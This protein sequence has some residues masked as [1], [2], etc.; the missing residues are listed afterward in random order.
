MVKI[1]VNDVS[2]EPEELA[3]LDVKKYEE[4]PTFFALYPTFYNCRIL[5]SPI[6]IQRML[7]WLIKTGYVTV[8]G[9]VTMKIRNQERVYIVPS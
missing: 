3:I 1:E 2:V 4:L 6:V 7:Q 5:F 9:K 8:D